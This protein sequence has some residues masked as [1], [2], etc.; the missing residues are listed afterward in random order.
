MGITDERLIDAIRRLTPLQRAVVALRFGADLEHADVG[1]ALGI[2]AVAAR[3]AAH[4]AITT[5]RRQLEDRP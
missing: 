3:N 2:S 4:R 1:T 5:L